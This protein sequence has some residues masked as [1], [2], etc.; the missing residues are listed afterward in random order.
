VR[1]ADIVGLDSQASATLRHIRVSM[2]AARAVAVSGSAGVAMGVIGLLAAVLASAAGLRS[3]WLLIWLC[4]AVVAAPTGAFLM[5]R[6]AALQG[7][8]LLG[9]PVR[10]VILCLLPGLFAGGVMTLNQYRTGDLHSIP[11]TWLLLYGCALV[12]TSAPTSRIVG[13][14]GSLFILLGLVAL[15]LPE[16]LQMAV[17]GG[18]F[19]ALQILFGI[20]IS[21]SGHAREI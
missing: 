21:K 15:G 19:G 7:F 17:L 11:G 3:H 5:A 9:A 12:A 2:D 8:T 6:R 14:L 10:K 16:N 18:G 1:G 20:L 4:A 13:V